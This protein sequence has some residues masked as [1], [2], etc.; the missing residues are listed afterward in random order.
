M[1]PSRWYAVFAIF[2]V[3]V[4]VV[5]CKKEQSNPQPAPGGPPPGPTGGVEPTGPHAEGIKVFN[6]KCSGCH[7]I[8]G[9]KKKGP[10]LGKVAAEPTHSE[11]YLRE[12]ILEPGAHKPKSGMPPFRGKI[13]DDEMKALLGYLLTLK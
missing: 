11:E 8:N 3:I 6:Q 9:A 13:S 7:A 5:G 2:A 4:L 1:I 12:F 10:D